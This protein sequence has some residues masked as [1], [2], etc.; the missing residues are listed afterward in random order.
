MVVLVKETENADLERVLTATLL[1]VL[2]KLESIPYFLFGRVA[3]RAR[4]QQHQV[5]LQIA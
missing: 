5:R 3:H 1:F 4:L 2:Q